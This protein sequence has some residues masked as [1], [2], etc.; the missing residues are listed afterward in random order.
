MAD[1][2]SQSTLR[3]SCYPYS[4]AIF[5]DRAAV[6]AWVDGFAD[7]LA[8]RD[9]IEVDVG[10]PA[11]IGRLVERLLSFL[12]RAR[13]HPS[14]PVRD[15]VHVRVDADV[16]LALERQDQ[17]EVRGLAANARQRQQL[18]HRARYATGKLVDEHAARVAHVHGF[19][20]IEADGIDQAL[21]AFGRE[22]RHRRRRARDRE[23]P[24]R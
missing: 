14:E 5:A 17:D 11:R 21:D 7:V 12:W 20:A 16:P 24:R 1:W 9:E 18:L 8:P 19:V 10:P 15:T 13:P 4:R 3:N 22:L 6:A 2:E 23:Q